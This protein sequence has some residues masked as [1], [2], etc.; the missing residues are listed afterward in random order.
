MIGGALISFWWYRDEE[1]SLSELE[2]RL[3]EIEGR[4]SKDRDRIFP[5]SSGR[6]GL[7]KI[8]F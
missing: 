8:Y 4:L 5:Y 1:K 7:L 2:C 6:F 3:A